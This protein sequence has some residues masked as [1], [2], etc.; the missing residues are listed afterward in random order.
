MIGFLNNKRFQLGFFIALFIL[1]QLAAAYSSIYSLIIVPFAVLLFYLGWQN[2]QTSFFLLLFSLAFSFEYSFSDRLA[3]D[4]PDEAL[5]V[6]VTGLFF[7][8]WVYQPKVLELQTLKHPLL[9]ML[10]LLLCWMVVSVIFST[11]AAV[12]VKYVLA[13][14]WYMG[15]FVLAPLIVFKD[16]R[17]IT[18]AAITFAASVLLVT[19]LILMKHLRNGLS[20]ATVNDSVVP[21]FRNHVNSS[22]MMVCTIPIFFA[23]FKLCKPG[24]KRRLVLAAIAILLAALYFSYARGAWL[25]LGAGLVTYWLVR[26]KLLVKAFFTTIIFA[27]LALFWIKGNDRYLRFAHDYNKTVYHTNFR[28]HLS[29]TYQLKDVSTAERFYRWIAGVRMIK[30]NWVTGYGPN[31]FYD[32]YKVYE[33]PAFR[34]WVSSN[35][36]R[37]TVHNYFLLV[38][39]EQGV[40][41]L[42]FFL[43][44]VSLMLYY[45]QHLYHRIRDGF[46]RT[47]AITIGVILSM[48][49]VINFLSDLIETDKIGSLFFLCLAMLIVTDV[50]TRK[51]R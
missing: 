2:I 8:Y 15:A 47:I 43:V 12:S 26:K 50:N 21:F 24:K 23:F 32:N 40:P 35:T 13:K 9:T 20:F 17:S 22:A 6:F 41:G 33:S 7:C 45:A 3:T 1:F 29:A 25:A 18:A 34:T 10:F 27:S 11:Q 42:I 39:I 49:L 30:N 51:E 28:D 38:T 37:S 46:Y 14:S 31:T 19:L 48:M 44:L 5:M 36:D 4:V 16:K